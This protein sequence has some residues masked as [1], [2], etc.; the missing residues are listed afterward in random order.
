MNELTK[1]RMSRRGFMQIAGI[2]AATGLLA[3]CAPGAPAAEAPAAE[4]SGAE[5]AAPSAASVEVQYMMNSAELTDQ[6][7]EQ[8]QEANPGITI[9]R[10]EPDAT[11]FFAMLTA[12]TPPDVYRLQAPQFPLLLARNIALNLQP[13]IDVSELIAVDDL[14]PAN[15]YYRS[16]GGALDIGAGDFYGMVKD[17]SPDMTV[18]ADLDVIEAAGLAVPSFT[19]AMDYDEYFAYGEKLLTFDGDRVAMRG[20]DFNLPW[21]DRMWTLW[22]QGHGES[23]FTDDYTEID[24]VE[25]EMA[26]EAVEY[27]YRLAETRVASS[28]VSPSPTWPGQDFANGELGLVQYGFWF[29]GGIPLWATDEIKAKVEEGRIVMLPAPKWKGTKLNTTITATGSIVTAATKNPD[30]AYKVFEWYNAAEPA[31]NRAASGWG[32]P[33][34]ISMYDQIPREGTYRSQVWGV[35]QQE[36]AS[37]DLVVKFNPYLQ[38]GEPGVTASLYIQYMEQALNGTIT[39]DEMLQKIEDETNLAIQDGIDTIG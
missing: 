32:V 14:A 26:R 35:L 12:G 22:L 4:S 23:I 3:A 5:P 6:E 2:S 16:S 18:W 29:S 13:Y 28:P 9:T 15:N 39:F 11:R 17:W 36:L 24:L 25:N 1:R 33:A 37:S 19:E 38:G 34:L 8:F 10:L 20:F 31:Q 27:T 21:V 7:I 30:E